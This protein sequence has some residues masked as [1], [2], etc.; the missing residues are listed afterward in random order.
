MNT[1]LSD[2]KAIKCFNNWLN[3][4]CYAKAFA[5]NIFNKHAY[6]L[7]WAENAW[8][9]IIHKNCKMNINICDYILN[10]RTKGNIILWLLSLYDIFFDYQVLIEHENIEPSYEAGQDM[11]YTHK[12]LIKI[13]KDL[14][15]EDLVFLYLQSCDISSKTEPVK[16][17]KKNTSINYLKSKSTNIVHLIQTS[18]FYEEIERRRNQI[19][20]AI[21]K[22]FNNQPLKILYFMAG[23]RYT[24]DV[25]ELSMVSIKHLS[26]IINNY[27]VH[28]LRSIIPVYIWIK[29]GMKRLQK[30]YDKKVI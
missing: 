25:D 24:G 2:V 6:M 12:D 27:D 17:S 21:Y 23:Y 11:Q 14:K 26:S 22:V 30:S 3:K 18:L 5:K 8:G 7:Y 29:S 1:K 19:I 28:A 10:K 15:Y 16:C 9:L 4:W 20:K 13:V